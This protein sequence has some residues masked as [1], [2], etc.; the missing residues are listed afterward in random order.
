V[1]E[2]HV[3]SPTHKVFTVSSE[4]YVF[5]THVELPSEHVHFSLPSFEVGDAPRNTVPY[6][7]PVDL[8]ERKLATLESIL[9]VINEFDPATGVSFEHGTVLALPLDNI[10]G[11]GGGA[12]SEDAYTAIME[13]MEDLSPL[14]FVFLRKIK[15]LAFV[16]LPEVGQFN[17]RI[18]EYQ[19]DSSKEIAALSVKVA[20]LS[21][22]SI[23]VVD[24]AR[25]LL[26]SDIISEEKRQENRRPRVTVCTPLDQAAIEQLQSQHSRVF[27]TLPTYNEPDQQESFAKQAFLLNAH[28]SLNPARTALSAKN[29]WNA[30]ILSHAGE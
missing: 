14:D 23:R 1:F 22:A 10:S 26:F 17:G 21:V 12:N 25:W 20:T 15:R 29:V 2:I 27:A 24:T 7:T 30:T 16:T 28:F 6:I 8:D 13:I 5:T 11:D 9:N 19:L 18:F 3:S 4:P